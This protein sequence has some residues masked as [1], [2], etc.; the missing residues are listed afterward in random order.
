MIHTNG[1]TLFVFVQ[2]SA[3]KPLQ[4]IVLLADACL[5]RCRSRETTDLYLTSIDSAE[6]LS[7][8]VA[9]HMEMFLKTLYN[10]RYYTFFLRHVISI[11]SN[12]IIRQIF[13]RIYSSIHIMYKLYRNRWKITALKF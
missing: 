3:P 5:R 6:F 12:R 4:Q 1:K 9:E 11:K 10:V 2:I 7:N 8:D 13:Y